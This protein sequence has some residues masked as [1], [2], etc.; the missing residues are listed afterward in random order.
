[1]GRQVVTLESRE[2]WT[3]KYYSEFQHELFNL[4]M[5]LMQFVASFSFYTDSSHT[6]YSFGC[7]L[8]FVTSVIQV[9]QNLESM[10][11]TYRKWKQLREGKDGIPQSSMKSSVKF[12]LHELESC[13]YLL[14]ALTFAAGSIFFLPH[15]HE[16]YVHA[17]MSITIGSLLFSAG[18][19]LFG[20]AVLVNAA[21]LPKLSEENLFKKGG[22]LA[23]WIL[24]CDQLA[25]ELYIAGSV[26]Y[27][28][29][30]QGACRTEWNIADL[31]T[32][33]YVTGAGLFLLS[34]LVHMQLVKL[35][36]N[37]KASSHRPYSLCEDV[38]GVRGEMLFSM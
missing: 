12:A 3:C 20:M 10:L 17:S 8:F 28:P 16:H 9:L 5:C 37:A 29:Q 11:E 36:K 7:F 2:N 14:G 32:H 19:F 26:L 34:S 15:V 27:F 4:A 35:K 38:E 25:C 30:L 18:S 1:M 22:L 23:R 13:I 31:G 24:G 21:S 6:F 33:L